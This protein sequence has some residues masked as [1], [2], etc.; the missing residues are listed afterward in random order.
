MP[1]EKG[2]EL[3]EYHFKRIVSALW[4]EDG[5]KPFV[6]HPW[7][8]RMLEA[9][10]R[11]KYLAVAGCA[12]SGKT[13]Y[14]AIWAIV[15]FIVAPYDTMVLVTSTTLKDSRKRIWGSIRDYWQAAPA[16]PGKLWVHSFPE[17]MAGRETTG[18]K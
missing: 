13:D 7:A 15:N 6:W 18:C 14:F 5:P 11:N 4:P 12:S 1:L 16:L 17:R 9:S 3:P 2:G 8:E 10:C